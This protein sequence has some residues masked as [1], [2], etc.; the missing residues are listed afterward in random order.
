MSSSPAAFRTFLGYRVYQTPMLKPYF[1]FM[2][3]GVTIYFLFSAAH[4][5]MM[6]NAQNKFENLVSDVKKQADAS[7]E[8]NKASEWY[9]AQ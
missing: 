9:N 4:I 7:V 8:K 3:T 2:I 1:P 6:N 5:A